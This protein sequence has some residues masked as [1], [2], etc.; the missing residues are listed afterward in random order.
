MAATCDATLA[1]GCRFGEVATGSYGLKP[2]GPLVH[3][4]V[5]R[6]VLG[7]NYKADVAVVADARA[8]LRAL[9]ERLG[10]EKRPQDAE[11]RSRISAGHARVWDAWVA[12]VGGDLVTPPHL[13]RAAQRIFGPDT[14]FT[15]DSGNGTFLAVECLRLEGPGT[16]PRSGGLFVH[17]IRGTGRAGR[18]ARPSPT[19]P[20]WLWP[21]TA[22][23]S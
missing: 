10:D 2:P 16:L 20:W 23:F 12:D 8:F 21:E 18:E 5:D 15:T 13:L 9:L 22:P 7:R 14:V 19:H 11:M 3:V 1:V 17:G 6:D 4:D